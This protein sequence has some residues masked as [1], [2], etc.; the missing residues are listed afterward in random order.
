MLLGA[1]TR[2]NIPFVTV[3][4]IHF[5]VPVVHKL[6][7]QNRNRGIEGLP[8]PRFRALPPWHDPAPDLGFRGFADVSTQ[9]AL[10]PRFSGR[11]LTS[12]GAK[13]PSKQSPPSSASPLGRSK[14]FQ[15]TMAPREKSLKK[16][17]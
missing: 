8:M 10:A 15:V 17:S 13:Q 9:D 2:Y 3:M 7:N 16:E 1:S 11:F 12:P 6:D 5:S 4:N 14:G